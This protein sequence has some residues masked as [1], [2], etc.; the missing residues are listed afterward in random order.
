MWTE[1][2]S[3]NKSVFSSESHSLS[4]SAVNPEII[5]SLTFILGTCDVNILNDFNDSGVVLVV[6][7]EVVD[8][9]VFP[10]S[11]KFSGLLLGKLTGFRNAGVGNDEKGR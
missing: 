11:G 8:I 7:L 5:F 1:N 9:S 2:H 4:S 10:C 3:F 6:R